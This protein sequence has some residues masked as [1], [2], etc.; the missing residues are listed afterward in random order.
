MPRTGRGGK[1][2][3][4]PGASYSNRTDLQNQPVRTAT[5]QPYGEAG[6]Q[7]AA[8]KVVPLPD[9]AAQLASTVQ[10][11]AQ[12]GPSPM[13][14]PST[15]GPQPIAAGALGAL[16]APSGRP[17]EP[18]TQGSPSGPGA[19]P[20]VLNPNAVRPNVAATIAQV[21]AAS[22]NQ[23]LMALAQRAQAQGA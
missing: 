12:G 13:A 3:A 21:A 10:A 19:G 11:A 17:A 5:N 6:S 22:G 1:V 2:A 4:T 15:N 14:G 20:E 16:N 8:Q 7:A 23:T 18:V 9:N